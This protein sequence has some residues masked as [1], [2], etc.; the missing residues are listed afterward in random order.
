MKNSELIN[1]VR[2]ELIAT[3]TNAVKTKGCIG[4]FYKNVGQ[5]HTI[6]QT[7]EEYADSPI[8]VVHGNPCRYGGFEAATV[9][10]LY[11]IGVHI[12]C[13]LNGESGEDWDESVENIQ[14]E[15]LMCIVAWLHEN[16]FIKLEDK[17]S[18]EEINKII[19]DEEKCEKLA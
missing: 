19:E 2:K 7:K 1:S 17:I 10:D 15:G 8:V 4:T 13:T 5:H 18:D 11:L 6:D 16:N 14:V 12:Q 3:I 9:Y